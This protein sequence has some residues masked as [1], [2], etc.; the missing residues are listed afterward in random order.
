M[1]RTGFTLAALVAAACSSRVRGGERADDHGLPPRPALGAP[2]DRAGRALTANALL[3]LMDSEEVSTRLKEQYNRAP[4]AERGELIPE[5]QRGLA[6][7]DAFDGRCGDQWLADRGAPPALRYRALATVLADDRLWI[8][9]RSTV[10]TRYLAVELAALPAPGAPPGDCGGRT[11]SH[12]AVD[13]FRSLLVMGAT[14][15]LDDGLP[16]DDREHSASEF[17]FLAA[18]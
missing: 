6:L 2:I 15:G 18:P 16:R 11:P 12:D 5:L 13:V 17:P 14:S 1:T 3:G 9:S 8:D 4:E 10:C 7:Y